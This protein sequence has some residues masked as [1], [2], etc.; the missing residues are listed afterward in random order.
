MQYPPTIGGFNCH[1]RTCQ[2]AIGAPYF[3]G[4]F[5]PASAL[6]ITGDYTIAASGNTVYR[7]FCQDCGT[8]LFGRN[9]AF[10]GIRPVAATTLDDPGIFQPQKDIWVAD[11]Q[12]WDTM[13]PDL[14]KFAGN[15]W[16]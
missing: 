6:T 11:A 12:S 1:C 9:S 10:T 16:H 3:A 4:M 14:P 8:S 7:G 5:V 2:K 13:N 15:P